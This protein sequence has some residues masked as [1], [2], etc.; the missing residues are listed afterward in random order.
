MQQGN[1]FV[2]KNMVRKKRSKQKSWE[3]LW[4]LRNS[5]QKNI[6]W[7]SLISQVYATGQLLSQKKYGPK[8][9]G[10]STKAETALE[11]AQQPSKKYF[12]KQSDFPNLCNRAT[13]SSKK[14]WSEKKGLSRKAEN[15]FGDCATSLKKIFSEAVWFPKSMQQ[16]NCFVKKN[17]VR[18]K[19]SKQKSWE[20]LWKLRN[21]PQKNIFWSSLISQ[22]HATGQLLRQK[23]YGL[24]K[25]GPSR[26][27]EN[28]FG[29]CATAQKKYF[30]KQ[31]DFQNPC[32]RA[33]ASSK[34]IWSK[35]KV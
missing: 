28:C 33:T 15:C 30:Q 27:A 13:A 16:G 22:I 19:R 1:C 4:R 34:K 32:N 2:K 10:L 8:K 29:D 11:T 5:P 25:K 26:K 17:M 3:L 7:S 18:K 12:L 6:F 23:K 31:S 20:L 9:K 14:I 24:K 21:I 35:K